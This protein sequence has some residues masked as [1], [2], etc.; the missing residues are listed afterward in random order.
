LSLQCFTW[1]SVWHWS[2]NPIFFIGAV[3]GLLLIA[4]EAHRVG[5]RMAIPYRATGVL[6]VGGMLIPLTFKHVH[7]VRHWSWYHQSSPTVGALL[8]GV[9]ILALLVVAIGALARWQGRW[10]T[11]SDLASALKETAKRQWVPVGVTALMA[12]FSIWHGLVGEPYLPTILANA[13]MFAMAIWLMLVGLREDRG[14]PFSAGVFYFLLWT[15]MR[16]FDLFGDFG[17]ML[18]GA[19]LFFLCGA[20]LFG[21]ALYWKKRKAGKSVISTPNA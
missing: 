14:Q 20:F 16:Y 19:M 2:H 12:F 9:A 1:D 10:N 8:Q 17:G 5:D 3:G 18:G 6:I 15:V 4:A 21:M 13:A 7:E 11:M